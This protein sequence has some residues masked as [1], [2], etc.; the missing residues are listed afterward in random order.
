MSENSSEEQV[1]DSAVEQ[2]SEGTSEWPNFSV[3]ILD[4]SGPQCDGVLPLKSFF[5]NQT[6]ITN[7]K[8]NMQERR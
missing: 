1:N 7:R 8:P 5:L 4:Y 2:M 6:R 3:C